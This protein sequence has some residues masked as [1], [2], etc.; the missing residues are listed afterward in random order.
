VLS[1]ANE[2]SSIRYAAPPI[3]SN[4]W[5]PPQTPAINRTDVLSARNFAS[6]C[7]QAGDAPYTGDPCPGLE[8]VETLPA[9]CRDTTT[10][11]KSIMGNEDCLFLS[12]Y[13]PPDEINLPVL[14]WIREF[15]RCSLRKSPRLT[16]RRRWRLRCR[17]W[18]AESHS[19]YECEQQWLRCRCDTI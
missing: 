17:G 8:N 9:R 10:F 12:V 4:R 19:Y 18:Y 16:V 1:P 2:A 3:G 6:R 15:F 14:V 11:Q 7:P 5:Q 13:A